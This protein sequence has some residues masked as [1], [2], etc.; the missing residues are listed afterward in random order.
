MLEEFLLVLTI[1][2]RISKAKVYISL[3]LLER[4]LFLSKIE[5]AKVV[6]I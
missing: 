4:E 3:I 6:L 1:D 2:Y 5:V